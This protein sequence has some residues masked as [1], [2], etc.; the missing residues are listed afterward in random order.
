MMTISPELSDADLA[1]TLV[2]VDGEVQVK[3]DGEFLNIT[4]TTSCGEGTVIKTGPAGVAELN[5][6][7]GSGLRLEPDT[8]MTINELRGKAAIRPDG[9]PGAYVDYLEVRLDRGRMFGA[10]A[11]GYIFKKEKDQVAT[12]L[13]GP[14]IPGGRLLASAGRLP[15]AITLAENDAPWWETAY[16]DQIRV[17]VDMP[18]GV[19]G[20]RGTFWSNLVTSTSSTTSVFQ[21]M[22][23]LTSAG[24]QVV[25]V[26]GGYSSQMSGTFT[27]PTPPAPMSPQERE[28]WN[29]VMGWVQQRAQSMQNGIL[30]APPN[31]AQ[32]ILNPGPGP[33]PPAPSPSSHHNGG[34]GGG[35]APRVIGTNPDNGQTGVAPDSTISITFAEDIQA[36][37]ADITIVDENGKTVDFETQINGRTLRLIPAGPLK[38]G[39][40]IS[41]QIEVVFDGQI[42]IG[43]EEDLLVDGGEGW[44]GAAT[45]V[46]GDTLVAEY[47]EFE[48]NTMYYITIPA[49]KVVRNGIG[50]DVIY[51][52]FTTASN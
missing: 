8:E 48:Y 29:Q 15:L 27:P 17:K 5:F 35:T 41:G 40:P 51:L 1:G 25:N 44:I 14:D 23:Q 7:D 33:N 10:L 30:S 19:A 20:V 3:K 22:V 6:P 47:H 34:G 36:G 38:N 18:W 45:V 37:D 24:G 32:Q 13:T 12:A 52:I 2:A 31:I 43:S 28:T 46:H 11:Y 16:D 26:P 42:E 39:W 50:N 21:G 49:G 4:G 9:T